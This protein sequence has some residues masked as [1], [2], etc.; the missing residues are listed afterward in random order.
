[1]IK[2][3]FDQKSRSVKLNKQFSTFQYDNTML[4]CDPVCTASLHQQRMAVTRNT[5]IKSFKH[6]PFFTEPQKKAEPHQH[7]SDDK[8]S[9]LYFFPFLFSPFLL[10]CP[11]FWPLSAICASATF[12]T[13]PPTGT[14]AKPGNP[15]QDALL[16]LSSADSFRQLHPDSD[17]YGGSLI[18][19]RPLCFLS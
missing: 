18:Y 7:Y 9:P 11:I 4:G 6:F 12:G 3:F 19:P 1:M 13:S 5:W 15:N 16:W 10:S 8:P 17:L 14:C 2:G